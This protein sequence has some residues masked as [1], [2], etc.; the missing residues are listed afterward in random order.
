MFLFGLRIVAI[1][2]HLCYKVFKKKDM[3]F[4]H[5]NVDSFLS[6]KEELRTLA[7][8]TY[9][10]ILGITEAKLDNTVSNVELN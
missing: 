8:N 10:S 1:Q 7:S 6:K 2:N 5:L 3:H 4:G 9:I